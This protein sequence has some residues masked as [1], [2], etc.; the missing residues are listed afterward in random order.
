MDYV[1]L[2]D[3]GEKKM[4]EKLVDEVIF[5]V[6]ETIKQV[7][8]ESKLTPAVAEMILKELY[9]DMR[10]LS[11]ENLRRILSQKQQEAKEE[12]ESDGEH[13]DVS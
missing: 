5:E 13:T 8:V 7:I 1:Q 10:D 12:V 9:L 3:K 6:R 11:Q 2:Y 4:K